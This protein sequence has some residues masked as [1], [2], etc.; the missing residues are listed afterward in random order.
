MLNVLDYLIVTLLI[1]LQIY[2][3]A[4]ADTCLSRRSKHYSTLKKI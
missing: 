3:E 4:D 1:I 2:C